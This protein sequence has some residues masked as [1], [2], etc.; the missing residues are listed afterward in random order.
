MTAGGAGEGGRGEIAP[1]IPCIPYNITIVHLPHIQ[2]KTNLRGK[3]EGDTAPHV[4]LLLWLQLENPAVQNK[5][6]PGGATLSGLTQVVG[7]GGVRVAGD[8]GEVDV[9]VDGLVHARPPDEGVSSIL[10]LLVLEREIPHRLTKIL[11]IRVDL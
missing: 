6:I 2:D 8:P 1:H 3:N 4:P 5:E 9:M 7:E 10:I 11:G